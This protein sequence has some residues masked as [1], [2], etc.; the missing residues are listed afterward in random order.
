[1]HLGI[2]GK[3]FS[4]FGVMLALMIGIGGFGLLKLDETTAAMNTVAHKDAAGVSAAIDAQLAVTM[5][6]RDLRQ[7]LL[8]KD[9]DN[10]ARMKASVEA[11]DKRLKDDLAKLDQVTI[12]PEGK[13]KL[14]TLNT[15]LGTWRPNQT[16][17]LELTLK[18]DRPAAE[19]LMLGPD[20]AKVVAAV[21][22]AAE[23][24]VK[25]KS[26]R[27]EE[28][29]QQ[30]QADVKT[31]RTMI[32]AVL[33]TA[34][35]IGAGL[36]VVLARN[37]VR[38]VTPVQT[39]LTSLAER[40]A[41]WLADGLRAVADGD[42]TVKL[43]PVTPL[44]EGYGTDEL[45][46][47]AATT[48]ALRDKIVAC[49]VA[50]EESRGGLQGIVSQVRS[51]ADGVADTSQQLGAATSQTSSAVQQ[52]TSAIQNVASGAQETSRSAQNSNEAVDQLAQVIEGVARGATEQ[53]QVEV[54]SE[55]TEPE[56][57]RSAARGARRLREPV[58]GMQEQGR[59]P[60]SGRRVEELGGLGGGGRR[61]HRR[62]R[63]AD[64][65]AGPERGH[66]GGP[67]GRAWSW[68]RGG[69]G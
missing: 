65:P 3:L 54:P 45:G 24:V 26:D 30:A 32:L 56:A 13:A 31:S 44:I 10:E 43:T 20:N 21:N 19:D 61:D 11:A 51:T 25:Y 6:Q 2:R 8:L 40:C 18:G 37:V 4:S 67:G 16:K 60:G 62:H 33:V 35:V 23:D 15:A 55:T 49:M 34:V 12:R 57:V 29:I 46:Q 36:A 64:Q 41:T 5:M 22:A 59:R 27:A 66:R 47:L 58:T 38:A 39:T 52:V 69:R 17:I 48:N 63:R 68:L 1:M 28:D 9:T 14:A 53:I 50:Y 7:L 42:L